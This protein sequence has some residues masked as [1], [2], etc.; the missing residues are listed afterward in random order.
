MVMTTSRPTKTAASVPQWRYGAKL[1]CL[2]TVPLNEAALWP[3][4]QIDVRAAGIDYLRRRFLAGSDRSTVHLLWWLREGNATCDYGEGPK[5]LRP[6]QVAICPAGRSHWVSINRGTARGVWIHLF[7]VKRWS[8]IHAIKPGIRPA[9]ESDAIEFIMARCIAEG[10]SRKFG[11]YENAVHYAQVLGVLLMR[12]LSAVG[13]RNDLLQ[14][15]KLD[16]L[17]REIQASLHLA[18]DVKLMAAK[19]H[20]SPRCFHRLCLEQLGVRP[21]EFVTRL[22][23]DYAIGRLL[24]TDIKIEQL[25]AEIGY[26]SAYAFSNTFLRLTGKR[27]GQFRKQP[28]SAHRPSPSAAR[29]PATRPAT[30]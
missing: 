19:V 28:D 8:F 6:G 30:G 1:G 22:R 27:P 21:L 26:Q 29:T 4:R 3:L 7:D 18:W 23:I 5:P 12:E 24:H 16:Q 10:D 20:V 9:V 17:S 11:A 14:R 2:E 13:G 15:E 25:A